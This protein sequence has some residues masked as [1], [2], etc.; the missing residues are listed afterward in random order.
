MDPITIS[1]LIGGGVGLV[2]SIGNWMSQDNTNKANYDLTRQA[3][4]RD[5]T[6][7]QRR[8]KDLRLAGLNPVLAAGGSG[9]AN[10]SPIPIKAPEVDT[11]GMAQA[12]QNAA[13]LMIQNKV[14]EANIA[15]T[16]ADRLFTLQQTVNSQRQG[17]LIDAQTRA[18]ELA[19]SFAGGTL[20]TRMVQEALK[21]TSAEKAI[22]L[23]NLE[24]EAKRRG[25]ALSDVEVKRARMD[26]ALGFLGLSEQD[27]RIKLHIL[28]QMDAQQSYNE[29]QRSYGILQKL[30]LPSVSPGFIS[31]IIK[32]FPMS[33][34]SAQ[35]SDKMD[36]RR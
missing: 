30:G 1:A 25:I 3:W 2:S 27:A 28:Q 21:K 23:Q 13:Q 34:P 35:F 22:I 20:E 4:R 6:A 15:K 5:D 9:A 33:G 19:N 10:S 8:V 11:S 26:E 31:E 36:K 24:A 16:E 12:A 14:A 32:Q 7:M 17:H 29:K 18:T